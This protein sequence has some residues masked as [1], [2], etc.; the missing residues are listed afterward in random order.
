MAQSAVL[1]KSTIGFGKGAQDAEEVAKYGQHVSKHQLQGLLSL[2]PRVSFRLSTPLRH[3]QLVQFHYFQG[4][5]HVVLLDHV[6]LELYYVVD[7]LGE[8]GLVQS[9]VTA[10]VGDEDVEGAEHHLLINPRLQELGH[11]RHHVLRRQT[12][13]RR[14]R[15]CQVRRHLPWHEVH[16][17]VA[18]VAEIGEEPKDDKGG[19]L[20]C[21]LECEQEVPYD[22]RQSRRRVIQVAPVE[23]HEEI[24]QRLIG[25][26]SFFSLC[27]WGGD[28][29]LSEADDHHLEVL[30]IDGVH[31]DSLHDPHS[32][33]PQVRR[34]SERQQL[35]Y[36]PYKDAFENL[37]LGRVGDAVVEVGEGGKE[38][39][40]PCLRVEAGQLNF[41]GQFWQCVDVQ[42][43]VKF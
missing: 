2:L 6:F 8:T 15:Y 43:A 14:S 1:C 24:L 25:Y 18:V 21:A 41:S 38:L 26:R 3:D 22:E 16:I 31:G 33:K 34:Q 17:P 23:Q 11:R 28:N 10:E 35:V 19:L 32:L 7:E 4:H 13:P 29:V 37:L 30:I 40:C 36:L 5:V 42:E 27:W 20:A 12:L 9:V 39:A